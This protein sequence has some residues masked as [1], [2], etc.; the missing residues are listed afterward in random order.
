MPF[1]H[2]FDWFAT[3]Y[4]RTPTL[5]APQLLRDVGNDL[6]RAAEA[7]R[8]RVGEDVVVPGHLGVDVPDE[9]RLTRCVERVGAGELQRRD[10][11]RERVVLGEARL[12]LLRVLQADDVVA[13]LRDLQLPAVDAAV[14]VDHVEVRVHAVGELGV[15]AVERVGLRRDD[16]HVDLGVGHARRLHRDVLRRGRP[17]PTVVAVVLSDEPPASSSSPELPHAAMTS[18]RTV[19]MAAVR[20]RA[21]VRIDLPPGEPSVPRRL[22]GSFLTLASGFARRQ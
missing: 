5:V 10:E 11:R 9:R 6:A 4:A 12:H 14:G 22:A 8:G 15:L 7:E 20:S 16:H 13:L 17:R 1:A 18:T 21:R 2:S 3:P 19:V